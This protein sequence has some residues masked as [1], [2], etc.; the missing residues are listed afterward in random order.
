MALNN[1]PCIIWPT[2]ID[3]NSFQVKCY[4]FMINLNKYNKSCNVLRDLSTIIC[5]PNKTKDVNVKVINVVVIMNKA[6]TLVKHIP[7]DCKWKF[8]STA[9]ISNK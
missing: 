2:V 4:P 1:E 9:C 3:F 6:K 8:N 5:V 7:C